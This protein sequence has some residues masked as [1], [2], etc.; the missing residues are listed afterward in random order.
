MAFI[1][2]HEALDR[3]LERLAVEREIKTGEAQ[4]LPGKVAPAEGLAIR[5]RG[6]H[7]STARAKP[8][9]AEKQRARMP[10]IR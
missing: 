4:H 10:V 6:D 7:G 8:R 2:L 1:T 5:A 9:K 3:V